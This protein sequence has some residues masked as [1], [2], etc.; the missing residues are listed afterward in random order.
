ML[1]TVLFILLILFILGCIAAFEIAIMMPSK[2]T[3]PLSEEQLKKA[4]FWC[5]KG[6]HRFEPYNRS[7]DEYTKKGLP[8]GV[9]IGMYMIDMGAY[10]FHCCKV[11][12]LKA[13][14]VRC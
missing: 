9:D 3:I 14:S 5:K 8:P 13:Q 4:G 12:G 10:N 6:Y 2:C 7:L 11:C 1:D